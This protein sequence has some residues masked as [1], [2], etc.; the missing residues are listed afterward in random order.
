MGQVIT[1]YVYTDL[2]SICVETSR[3]VNKLNEDKELNYVKLTVEE[4]NTTN[5]FDGIYFF[6]KALAD[7]VQESVFEPYKE[8]LTR[9]Q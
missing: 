6:F 7:W 1:F 9:L 3:V 2:K 5:G 8:M 4:K